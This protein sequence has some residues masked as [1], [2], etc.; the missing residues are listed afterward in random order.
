MARKKRDLDEI[1]RTVAELPTEPPSDT[2]EIMEQR[3][4]SWGDVLLYRSAM[5]YVPLEDRKRKMVLVHCSACQEESYL[6]Y[7]PISSGCHYSATIDRFGFIDPA[8]GELKRTSSTCICP[9]CGKGMQ[10]L[11]ISRFQHWWEISRNFC[12]TVHNVRG[13]LVLLS[14]S[15]AKMVNKEGKTMIK[16]NMWEG[17][18]LVNGTFVRV[19]GYVR[20]MSAVCFYDKWI[21][22]VKG[23]DGIEDCEADEIIVC[24]CEMVNQTD[25]AHSAF[26]EYVAAFKGR[27]IIYPGEYLKLW[28]RHPNVENLIR[29]GFSSYVN[30]VLKESTHVGG[31]YYAKKSFLMSDT[32]QH[33][34]WKEVKPHKMLSIEKQELPIARQRKLATV[35]FYKEMKANYGIKLSGECL[36][37]AERLGI[38]SIR[39]ILKEDFHGYHVPIVKVLHYLIKQQNSFQQKAEKNLIS[40]RYLKD[41]WD[42]VYSVYGRMEQ[43]LL[44]PRDLIRAH[45]NMVL[46]VKEKESA[47]I[48][49]QI[50]ERIDTLMEELSYQSA[51][52]GLMIRPAQSHGE[53]I[54]EGKLLCHCVGGYAK[55]HASGKT[56][57]LLIRKIEE[58]DI[59]FYTLEYK[60]GKVE[61]NRGYK[62]CERTSEVRAFEKEWLEHIKKKELMNHGKRINEYRAEQRTGA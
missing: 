40:I 49:A 29:Q 20:N 22:R 51:E 27:D 57:I 36:E 3:G 37:A 39:D 56:C 48:N 42:A 61:Q 10:A 35:D 59:P 47:E 45:D 6:E 13:H 46:R 11:H 28:S 8:D 44:Y 14:W 16:A 25:S 55:A 34:N 50:A 7:E 31:S 17:C 18:V 30:S 12:A 15:I 43:A 58:P 53:L 52:L 60:N 32:D 2:F 33:I 26:C 21:M 41:Y 19:V 54:K 9:S 62:N 23:I 1:E 4:I 24:P 38:Y 5:V